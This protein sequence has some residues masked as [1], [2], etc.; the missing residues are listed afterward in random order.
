MSNNEIDATDDDLCLTVF[1]PHET[2]ALREKM[3]AVER[4]INRLVVLA[5]ERLTGQKVVAQKPADWGEVD[6][7]WESNQSAEEAAITYVILQP[8]TKKPRARKGQ[9]PII[10][11]QSRAAAKLMS[12][13]S[14][15][16]TLANARCELANLAGV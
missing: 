6:D 12:L 4:E 9:Q 14:A 1:E 15:R 10:G 13:L 16:A 5:T 2:Q 3:E 7:E 8:L 11:P